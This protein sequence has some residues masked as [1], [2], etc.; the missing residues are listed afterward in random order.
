MNSKIASRTILSIGLFSALILTSCE[1]ED[2]PVVIPPSTTYCNSCID[3]DSANIQQVVPQSQ[4]SYGSVFYFENGIAFSAKYFN[5]TGM[6]VS[7]DFWTQD[8]DGSSGGHDWTTDNPNFSGDVLVLGETDLMLDFST[9]S[10]TNKSVEFDV[11]LPSVPTTVNEFRANGQGKTSL[12]TGIT[13]TYTQLSDGIHVKITGPINT[14]ELFGF[15][16]AY[17]NIC[18]DEFVGTPPGSTCIDFQDTTF[19]HSIPNTQ[20]SFGGVFLNMSGVDFRAK[21]E[22]HSGMNLLGDLY[23]QDEVTS[24]YD[25]Y[26]SDFDQNLMYMG[27][28]SL[29]LDFTNLSTGNKTISFDYSNSWPTAHTLANAFKVNGAGTSTLPSGVTY[30][31]TLLGNAGNGQPCYHVEISGPINTIEWRGFEI[32]YDNLCIDY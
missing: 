18:V 17:D 3:F 22:N 24:G 6:G 1:K 13:Y 21:Y 23:V 12:P 29:Q 4:T 15:E 30:T 28:I 31:F 19:S 11:S 20:T 9:V 7:G 26:N 2:P 14:L 5:H 8:A 27:D 32:A 10:Y 25:Q 16:V